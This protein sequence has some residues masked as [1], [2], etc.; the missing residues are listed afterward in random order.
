MANHTHTH[1]MG[2]LL[3]NILRFDEGTVQIVKRR[4]TYIWCFTQ[5]LYL[6]TAKRAY[7]SSLR[8]QRLFNFRREYKMTPTSLN[9][10]AHASL[11]LFKP[12]RF[13]FPS[14]KNFF[15]MLGFI[16]LPSDHTLQN[17]FLQHSESSRKDVLYKEMA[18]RM[19]R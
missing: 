14:F 3:Y 5:T 18:K 7:F 4:Y 19:K 9:S 16:L 6:W 17:I 11:V 2:C 13:E 1:K 12:Y 8:V 10:L 15:Q